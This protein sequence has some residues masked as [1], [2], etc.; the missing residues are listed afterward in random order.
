VM[1][2]AVLPACEVVVHEVLGP[3]TDA[4]ARCSMEAWSAPVTSVYG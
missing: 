4:M 3:A 1:L 2:P